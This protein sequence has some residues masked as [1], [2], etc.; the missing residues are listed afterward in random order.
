MIIYKE[1]DAG[2]LEYKYTEGAVLKAVDLL[3]GPENLVITDVKDNMIPF[4][5]FNS[6]L[7]YSRVNGEPSDRSY[8][9]NLAAEKILKDMNDKQTACLNKLQEL[10]PNLVVIERKIPEAIASVLNATRSNCTVFIVGP[11][12]V[13]KDGENKGLYYPIYGYK[14]IAVGILK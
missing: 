11:V 2:N 3:Q 12:P 13:A 5:G 8:Y 4:N 14:S 1:A 7:V 6:K 10:Y 9:A